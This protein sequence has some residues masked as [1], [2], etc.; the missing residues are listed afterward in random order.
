VIFSRIVNRLNNSALA[1]HYIGCKSL[2]TMFKALPVFE[3]FTRF[4]YESRG[5]WTWSQ[6][7]N[8]TSRIYQV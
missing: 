3:E 5:I 2:D 6:D 1:T 8:N 4:L 7:P